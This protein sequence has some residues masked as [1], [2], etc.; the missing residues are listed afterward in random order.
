M[1]KGFFFVVHFGLS[2]VFFSLQTNSNTLLNITDFS[3][4]YSGEYTELLLSMHAA[5]KANQ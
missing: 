4:H 5:S 3:V 2:V 1:E